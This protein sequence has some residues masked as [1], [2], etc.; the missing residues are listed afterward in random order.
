MNKTPLLVAMLAIITCGLARGQS[1]E[2]KDDNLRVTSLDGLWRFH[3]G[4][5]PSWADPN[6]NDSK[7]SL[8]RSDEDW[9][10]QGFKGYGGMA[11]YRFRVIV[12]AGLDRISLYLP[13]LRTCYEVFAN[14]SLIGTYGKMPPNKTAY[15]GGGDYQVYPL[16]AGKHSGGEIEIALRVWHWPGWATY[17]GGGPVTGGG[18]VGDNGQIDQL[19]ALRWADLH[20]KLTSYQTLA[21]L[22]MLAGFGT[23]ALFVLRYKEK[24]YLWFSLMMLLSAASGWISVLYRTHVWNAFLENLLQNYLELGAFFA[25]IAFYLFLL[26]PG[27]GLLLKL[28]VFSL[29]LAAITTLIFAGVG[30]VG[31][32]LFNVL[33]ALLVLPVYF[34]TLAVLFTQARRNSADARLLVLPAALAICTR[35]FE[36]GSWFTYTLGWQHRIGLGV[37][38]TQ[39]PF[40]IDLSQ[41]TDT[42]FLL[43]VLGVLILR[44]ARTRSQEERFAAEVQAARG[45]QQFLIPEHLPPTPGLVIDSVYLPAREVGGDFFQVLPNTTDGSVLIVVGDVAGHGMESGMLATLIVGAIRTA[46]EF[47]SDPGRILTLL[48]KRMHGRGLA[49]CL[50]LRIE[51]DG[52]AALANA[53][54]LPPYVN[55]RELAMEGALPLGAIAGIDFPILHFKLAES[56][57][58]M[59]MTD[60]VAEAQDAEGRLFGFDRIAEMLRKGVAAGALAKAAQA[61]GQEDDI[62]VL[63]VVRSAIA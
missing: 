21:L 24:E 44:F 10:Q 6:F 55:C 31:I 40:Q 19:D 15:A 25:S 32:W 61:F 46:A 5:D 12:P 2:I 20:W 16:P 52:S 54:H 33:N 14:G 11:W 29:T 39:K 53:G 30:N 42:L 50:A 62:T 1:F 37:T 60:G 4:D 13:H 9:G 3:T 8:L 28:A 58:L 49:T 59:L 23:L 7:W 17:Y 38:L 35:I 18:L 27:R 36:Q 34:W 57:T 56:G 26:R 43:A 51:R 47:T 63:T 45:V 48:N 41:A 22:Q